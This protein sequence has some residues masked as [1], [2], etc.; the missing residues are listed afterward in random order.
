MRTIVVIVSWV[1]LFLIASCGVPK[2]EHEKLIAERD[3]LKKVNNKLIVRVNELQKSNDELKFPSSDRLNQIKSLISENKFSEATKEIAELKRLFPLSN[4]SKLVEEQEQI[5]KK[6]I[7]EQEA[8]KAR[9]KALGFKVFQDNLSISV[10][11]VSCVFS[12][13][14][15]GRTFAFDHVSDISEYSYRTADKDNVYLSASLALSTKDNDAS[16]P[17]MGLYVLENGRLEKTSYIEEEYASW[18]TYGAKIGNYSE[19]SHDFSKVNTVRYKIG[20]EISKEQSQKPL[21]LL[22]KKEGTL[23]EILSVED[24]KN[25]YI[26]IKIMNKN[27]I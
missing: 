7:A 22:T 16:V 8:E 23:E 24:V 3:S 20:V 26:V 1:T 13:F 2:S 10:G 19:T 14:S 17:D 21:F 12:G 6:K 4:E 25:D 15:F 18:A 5:I 27:R 9:L 11:N